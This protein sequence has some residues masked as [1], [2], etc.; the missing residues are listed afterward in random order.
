MSGDW[1]EI[2]PPSPT[3]PEPFGP[4]A[5]PIARLP[6]NCEPETVRNPG[7]SKTAPPAASPP[8][9]SRSGPTAWLFTKVEPVMV[10][11]TAGMEPT[12]ARP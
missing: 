3:V 11:P 9:V 8:E 5:P 6:W 1:L 2:A 10:S 7:P 12:A 4:P